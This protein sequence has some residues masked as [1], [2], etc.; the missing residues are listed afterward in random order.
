MIVDI[1]LDPLLLLLLLLFHLLRSIEG[2]A[3]PNHREV[4][5]CKR[6]NVPL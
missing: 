4:F 6:P 3:E 5:C 1:V 2:F